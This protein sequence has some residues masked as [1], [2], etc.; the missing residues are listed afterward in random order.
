MNNNGGKTLY[1]FIDESGNFDFSPKGTKY[2]IL[3]CLS[4]FQPIKERE[5][6]LNL[7]YQL[8]DAG[9]NQEFFH[10]TEDKQVVRNEVFSILNSFSNDIEIDSVIVQKNKT[11]PSLYYEEYYKKGRLIKR[12]I[13]AD[14][15]QIVCRTLLQYVFKRSDSQGA[16]K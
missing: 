11:N 10:A 3:S 13:G 4:T 7:R 16:E 1:L 2:F 9:F 12:I 6:L 14:F 15:Y 5:K 8:L